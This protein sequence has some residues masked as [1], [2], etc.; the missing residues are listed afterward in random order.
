MKMKIIAL[1]LVSVLLSACAAGEP[2]S[3]PPQA[4]QAGAVIDRDRE[5]NLITLPQ[6]IDR[7]ISMGP[8]K[9]EILAAL[10]VGG[11]IIAADEHS[12]GIEGLSPDIPLFSV[13]TPDPEQIIALAPDV[14][15]V[16]GL[17]RHGGADPFRVVVDAG[18]CVIY[19]PTSSSIEGIKEDIRFMA[20]VMGAKEEGAA[21]VAEME[22]KIAAIRAVGETITAARTVY[23]EIEA[24]PHM[25]SFGGGVFL[26]EMLEIIGAVNIFADVDGWLSVSD[27]VIL[28]A[29]PDVILTNVGWMDDPI[30]EI[31]SRPGWETLAAVQ[32]GAVHKIDANSSSRPSHHITLALTQMAAAIYPEYF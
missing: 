26:S 5:G 8:S 17:L 30:G 3:A 31:I 12:A 22:S 11:Q 29:N 27:E 13:L 6:N 28:V 2:V 15:F 1:L 32:N 14:I 19:I 16:A 10:G 24:A 9:T 23:F 4:P 7:I 21:I 20:A 25:F 18:I